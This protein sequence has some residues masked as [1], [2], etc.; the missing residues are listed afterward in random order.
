MMADDKKKKV[1]GEEPKAE[2]RD[3]GLEARLNSQFGI[4]DQIR[5]G[6]GDSNPNQ[7]QEERQS[8]SGRKSVH[9]TTWRQ[10]Q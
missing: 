1:G 2:V 7:N 9:N 3:G 6:D 4:E 5:F 8:S 10:R